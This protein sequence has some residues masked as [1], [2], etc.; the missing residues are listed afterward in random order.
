MLEPYQKK[1]IELFIKQ[2]ML[3][4]RLYGIFA[5]HFP[6]EK[7][8]W[9][10]LSGDEKKHAKWLKQLFEAEKKGLVLFDEGRVKTHAL[11]TFIQYLEKKINIAEQGGV[12]L[13][14]AAVLSLDLER[15]LLEKN[16][17]SHFDGLSKNAE[18]ILNQLMVETGNHIARVE[19]KVKQIK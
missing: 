9:A 13:K 8:F 19:S 12:T 16:A 14:E 1:I 5:K 15:A 4:S 2:E 7:N 11:N 6:K 10:D 17:F 3:L 18:G